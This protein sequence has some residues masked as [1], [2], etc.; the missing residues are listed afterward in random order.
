MFRD[1][2]LSL[3]SSME[4]LGYQTS[5]FQSNP[6]CQQRFGFA[7]GF[8]EYRYISGEK[9]GLQT[10]AVLEKLNSV[11]DQP[12][13]MFIHEIDPH[14]P[15]TP[16]ENIYKKLFGLAPQEHLA[17]LSVSDQ[18][19]I[20][21][22]DLRYTP[23][24]PRFFLPRLRELSPEGT[25]YLK[26]LYDAEI[27]GVDFHF[28]RILE[29][30][31]TLGLAENTV[32]CF[33]SDH[34][35]AFGEHGFYGHNHSLYQ[36][37]LHVPMIIHLPGQTAGRRIPWNMSLY[38][39]YPTL[40]ALGGGEPEADQQAKSLLTRDG[41]LLIGENRPVYA[42][43]D[44]SEADMDAWQFCLIDGT[45]KIIDHG[46]ISPPEIYDLSRDPNETTNIIDVLK[47]SARLLEKARQVRRE[48]LVI[49]QRY[50]QAE[51]YQKDQNT[52]EELRALGYF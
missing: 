40:V 12:F 39:L 20:D 9:P 31:E 16:E 46:E 14:S 52:T 27:H 1:R 51:Y 11:S 28:G 41:E 44:A 15:Y 50:G 4:R 13:F 35:Q 6:H 24:V 2:F 43:Y 36:E 26:R 29:R 18:M 33:I 45:Y 37:V 7:R 42:Y 48:H 22:Y 17:Q 10:D 47:D 21:G 8:A 49:S 30:L 3:A 38:D 19:I 25:N 32:V 34:G 5:L 23:D